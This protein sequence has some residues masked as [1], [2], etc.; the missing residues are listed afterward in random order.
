MITTT[1][2]KAG[3]FIGNGLTSTFP[4]TFKVFT[5]ANLRV[6]VVNTS[7]G[8]E[9]TLT[10]MSDYTVSLG[11]NQDG[12]PGGSITLTAGPLATGFSLIITS[13]IAAL[14]ETFFASLG[15]FEPETVNDSLDRLTILIQQLA[16]TISRVV[17][18]P[19][20]DPTANMTLPAAAARAG[21]VLGFDVIGQPAMI[22]SPA[23]AAAAVAAVGSHISD[24]NNPH[25][26]TKAQVGLGN[27]DNIAVTPLIG[28]GTSAPFFRNRLVNG[29]FRVSQ[30]GTSFV[31]VNGF[32]LDGWFVSRAGGVTGLNV[33]Q[34][35]GAFSSTKYAMSLQRA[36][37]NAS[38]AASTAYAHPIEGVNC[39]DLAG[40]SVTFALQIGTGA[41][42]AT[43]GHSL[44]IYYQT[45]GSDI[46]VSGSWTLLSQQSFT[47]SQSASFT[48]KSI[49]AV[50]PANA[51]QVMASVAFA[52]AGTAGADDRFYISEG[53]LEGGTNATAFE[54]RPY[55]IELALCQRYYI[56]TPSVE[57]FVLGSAGSYN[58]FQFKVSMRATPT[59]TLSTGTLNAA[60]T[61]GLVAL[62]GGSSGCSVI[63]T[64]ELV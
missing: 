42:V 55:S 54:R 9:T 52:H 17:L 41:N 37:G 15:A 21:G 46:G 22:S 20:T 62:S 7:T 58:S 61:E 24:T 6:V 10:L 11:D 59:V 13:S 56:Q 49:T 53:Q 34:V 31:N 16:E 48:K 5:S 8:A 50:L 64:A 19:V 39:R 1:N 43:T 14:Q 30:R 45:T 2:R 47:L 3:P 27:V 12:N 26:T 33:A 18:T 57:S 40:K 63:A 28:D 35:Y 60:N 36:A 4:F 23:Y 32:R 51:T 29:C 38:T 25:G 44:A